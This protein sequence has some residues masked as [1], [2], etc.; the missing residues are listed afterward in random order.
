MRLDRVAFQRLRFE[1]IFLFFYE[2]RFCQ[3][4]GSCALF[5]G[6][7]IFFFFTKTFIKNGSHGTIH[8]F[9][10]YFATVFSVF[11]KLSS[12]QTH[13]YRRSVNNLK[14]YENKPPAS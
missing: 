9:E 14:N 8:I 10:N 13:I 3:V 12:I 11:S 6:P 1:F 7:K 2:V 4:C 5:T